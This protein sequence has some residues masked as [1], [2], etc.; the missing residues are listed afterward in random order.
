[1]TGVQTCALPISQINYIY[2]PQITLPCLV[3]M[4][5]HHLILCQFLPP[6]LKLCLFLWIHRPLLIQLHLLLFPL[7]LIHLIQT[8]HL[9]PSFESTQLSFA[10]TTLPSISTSNHHH[11]QTRSKSGI[12]KPKSKFCYKV[13]LD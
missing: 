7:L 8:L 3:L 11:M 9:Y 10:L 13:I 12:T 6:F 5:H 4:H 1:M 2:T